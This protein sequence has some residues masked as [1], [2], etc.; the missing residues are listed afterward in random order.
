MRNCAN[1]GRLIR[2]GGEDELCP[3]CRQGVRITPV[4]EDIDILRRAAIR[5]HD[6][7]DFISK[8]Q[9]VEYLRKRLR[10]LT[11]QKNGQKGR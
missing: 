6:K 2:G 7:P 9:F 8:T 5:E 1:C 3:G 10:I 11:D 4:R